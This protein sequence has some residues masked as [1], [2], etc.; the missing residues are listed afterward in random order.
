MPL[1]RLTSIHR[2]AAARLISVTGGDAAYIA[3]V[4]LVYDRTGSSLW[5]SAALL[6]MIG[7]GGACAPFAGAL[8][9]RFD[10]RRVLIGSD[11]AAAACFGAIA[12][13]DE[14]WQLVVL[15]GLGAAAESPFIPTSAASV[16]NL[17][18]NDEELP[19]ANAIVATG[20]NTG[21][22]CGPLLGGLLVATLGPAAAFIGNAITF[23]ASAALVATIRVPMQGKRTAEEAHG[24]ILAGFRFLAGD[25]VLR[26]IAIAWS[27]VLLGIGG[28]LVAEYPLAKE[29]DAGAVGYG[30]LVAAWGGGSLL[31]VTLAPRAMRRHAELACITV[32]AFVMAI[33]IGAVAVAPVL[34]VAVAMMAAGGI[35]DGIAAVA[36]ETLVQRR[37]PDAV[38]SRVLA[39]MEAAV[40]IALALSFGFAGFLLDA[41]G[42]RMTYLIAG[43]VFAIGA[44]VIATVLRHERRDAPALP[45]AARSAG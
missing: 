31:G 17:V 16:P 28:V 32:G 12:L 2:L 45:A 18:A 6:A 44:L 26:T 33:A 15:A 34:V 43:V 22:L 10:R 38:R 7:I 13:V 23:L 19:R 14:P 21:M 1:L 25:R 27:I 37:V 36:E 41:V 39:A 20:K 8:G 9:D 5:V 11:L 3:L 30:F 4:A 29:F 42:P 40:L 24:G 35:A